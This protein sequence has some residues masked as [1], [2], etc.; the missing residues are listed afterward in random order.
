MNPDPPAAVAARALTGYRVFDA[1]LGAL[2][3]IVPSIIP[4]AGEGGVT[5]LFVSPVRGLIRARSS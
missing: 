2:A 5:R 3:K 1:M 4:A